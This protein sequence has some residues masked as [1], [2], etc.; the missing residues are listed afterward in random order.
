MNRRPIPPV[1]R[2]YIWAAGNDM[3]LRDW[4][5][6]ALVVGFIVFAAWTAGA[7]A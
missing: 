6:F 3:N 2:W 4:I 7:F 5:D 1:T